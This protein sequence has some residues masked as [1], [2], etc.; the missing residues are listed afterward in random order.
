M[1]DYPNNAAIECEQCL[2]SGCL[3]CGFRGYYWNI[4]VTPAGVT[5]SEH[6]I[7]P[8]PNIIPEERNGF[9]QHSD[10]GRRISED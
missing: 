1:S 4:K 10:D 6:V 3:A 8:P 7:E 9:L 2:G 5:M